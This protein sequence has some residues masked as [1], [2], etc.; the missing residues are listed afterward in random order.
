LFD[1][2][3]VDVAEQARYVNPLRVPAAVMP[4]SLSAHGIRMGSLGVAIHTT[5]RIAVPFVVGDGGP[6]IGEGS[7]ALARLVAGQSLTDDITRV[8]RFV[9]QVDT[10]EVLWVFF[11]GEPVTFRSNA[12]PALI[13]AAQAA[14]SQWGG[15]ARL[16]QC[17]SVVPKN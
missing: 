1:A 3:I 8:N 4:R 6:R 5:K 2:S 13:E 7:V 16:D 17:L 14:F 11:G 9:G 12:A 15:Q 10:R